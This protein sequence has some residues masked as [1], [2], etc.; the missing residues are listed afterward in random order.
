MA[1]E[2]RFHL[3]EKH[4]PIVVWKF[5]NPPRN[6]ASIETMEEYHQLLEDFENDPELL[7]G[8]ITSATPGK[9]IQHFDVSTIADWSKKMDEASEEELAAMNAEAEEIQVPTDF[10]TKPVICAINGPLEGGGCELSLYC[11]FRFMSRDAFLG[12]P[13]VNA[14]FPPGYGIPRLLQLIGLDKTLELCMTGRRVFADEAERIGLVTRA[15]DPD[16][17]EAEVLQFA[18]TLAGKSPVALSLI[19]KIIYGCRDLSLKDGLALNR[20]LF[21]EGIQSDYAKMMMNLYLLAGQDSEKL[22]AAIITAGGDMEKAAELLQS[23]T[24]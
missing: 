7:V 3:V 9:F 17:L 24:H 15:C 10:T 14:G 4:G 1:I 19:K 16:K 20:D 6:L 22:V 8:I 12:Q 11:D 2:P 5:S 21:I 13:E 23:E 18:L